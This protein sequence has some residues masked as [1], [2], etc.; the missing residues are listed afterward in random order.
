MISNVPCARRWRKMYLVLIVLTTGRVEGHPRTASTYSQDIGSSST[1]QMSISRLIEAAYER[2][3]LLRREDWSRRTDEHQVV[4]KSERDISRQSEYLAEG[5]STPGERR[6]LEASTRTNGD[7][8]IFPSDDRVSSMLTSTPASDS[9]C[10]STFCEN[11][12]NYPTHLVNA[13]IARN[14]SL[15]FLESVDELLSDPVPDIEH[16]IK[17][18]DE[19]LCDYVEHL[20]YPQTAQNKEKQW[21]FVVNLDGLKQRIRVEICLNDGQEC[22]VIKG[23]AENYKTTCKQKFI[24]RELLA[25]GTNGNIV[26][27]QFRFPSSCCCHIKNTGDPTVRLGLASSDQRSLNRT[28]IAAKTRL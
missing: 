22:N 16:R 11:V 17:P 28:A 15:R 23:F 18:T 14:S 1:Q 27:D 13:A 12:T 5:I 19:K 25:V 20:V 26:K 6:L 8:I 7:G 10:H 9:D 24:Y 4:T 21:L 2:Q 3:E